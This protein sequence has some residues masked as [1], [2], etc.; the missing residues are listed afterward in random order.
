[1]HVVYCGICTS[2]SCWLAFLRDERE[3]R[4]MSS[5]RVCFLVEGDKKGT[6]TDS[7]M[8]EGRENIEFK[9]FREAL[10]SEEGLADEEV[11]LEDGWEEAEVAEDRWYKEV[12]VPED[13]AREGVLEI[14]VSDE[15]LLKWSE[16]W[17]RTLVINV[18]GRKV[19][20]RALENKLNREWARD[21][22]IKIIDMPRGYYAVQFAEDADYTHALFEGSWMV[23]DHY[24]L[25]QRWRRNFL[26]S[27]RVEHKVA[28]WVRAPELPLELYNDIFLKRLG[29]S[30]GTMLKIDRLTSVHS[31]G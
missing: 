23:A 18:L 24:I 21:G 3:S 31:R 2:C 4:E 13:K 14:K 25:V 30:L 26:K 9:S 1:M 7:S 20:F 16:Q 28:V 19:N 8:D 12:E 29:S 10:L 5:A 17:E 11:V 22:K 15:E 27:A 6:V